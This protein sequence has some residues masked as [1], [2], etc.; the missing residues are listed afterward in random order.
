MRI[1]VETEM[2]EVPQ[3]CLKYGD[4]GC[5]CHN[6]PSCR[7]HTEKVD[8]TKRPDWCPLRTEPEI[9]DKAK[10]NE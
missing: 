3:N 4:G 6:Y 7:A 10:E 5:Y 2:N 1:Y 9:V 8:L